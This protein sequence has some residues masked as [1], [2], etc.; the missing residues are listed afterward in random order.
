VDIVGRKKLE[1]ANSALDLTAAVSF[2]NTSVDNVNP[3]VTV[4]TATITVIGNA[5]IRDAQTGTPRNKQILNGHYSFDAWAFDLTGTRYSSYRYNVGNVA[6]VATANGN[7]D[8]EFSP[9]YYVDFGVSY[10]F[11][12]GWRTDLQLQN[13]LNDYPEKYVTGN[14][15]SGINPYS[16]I[17]PNGASGRFV[18]LSLT[19]SL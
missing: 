6:G 4:G 2:L 19:Y 17:A 13:L 11:Q 9:E 10:A 7:I 16:F 15:S 18:Q 14:R 12:G 1:F 8:Q 5:R 3:T